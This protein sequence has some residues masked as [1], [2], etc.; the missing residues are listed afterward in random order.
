MHLIKSIVDVE[1]FGTF[2]QKY[3]IHQA[4]YGQ[5]QPKYLLGIPIG[6]HVLV[7]KGNE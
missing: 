6:T 7:G 2:R 3:T 4:Y 5:Y 1:E